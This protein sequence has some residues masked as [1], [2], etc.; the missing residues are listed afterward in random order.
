MVVV[1]VVVVVGG[2]LVGRG[3]GL[4]Q[5]S[6][7]YKQIPGKMWKHIMSYPI[8]VMDSSSVICFYQILLKP[9]S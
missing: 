8:H 6:D 1:V 9:S 2:G 3:G 5:A 7:K 4:T